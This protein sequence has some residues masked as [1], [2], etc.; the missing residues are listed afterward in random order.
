VGPPISH[1]VRTMVPLC[2]LCSDRG[3]CRSTTPGFIAARPPVVSHCRLPTSSGGY[4]MST[5][6]C[7]LHFS[8]SAPSPPLRHCAAIIEPPQNVTPVPLRTPH[9]HHELRTGTQVD[10]GDPMSGLPQPFLSGRSEPPQ[11]ACSNPP[12][13][14]LTPPEAPRRRVLPPQLLGPRW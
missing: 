14:I 1:T 4:K 10:A 13:T 5:L 3:H 6:P 9:H 11:I 8:S 12:P 7:E 2:Q